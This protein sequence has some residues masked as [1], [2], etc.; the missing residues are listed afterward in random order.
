MGKEQLL[1]REAHYPSW[2]GVSTPGRD[3]VRVETIQ[4]K[5]TGMIKGMENRAHEERL[6]GLPLFSLEERGGTE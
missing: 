5:V 3:V 6:K 1:R 4:Q 2:L